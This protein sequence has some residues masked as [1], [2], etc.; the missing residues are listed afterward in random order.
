MSLARWVPSLKR[1]T[2]YTVLAATL[3]VGTGMAWQKIASAMDAK[4]YPPPGEFVNMGNYNIHFLKKGI[5][6]PVVV[7]DAG[8][9]CN[10]LDWKFVQEALA[11]QAQVVS[12]DRPGY[13]WSD[14]S[15]HPRTS[16]EIATELHEMLRRAH[17]A[18][19]YV[20]VGHSFGGMN[21]RQFALQYPEE[22]AGLVF[23]DSCHE[24]QSE[25]IPEE[26]AS[27]TEA[28]TSL[29]N[30]EQSLWW[31]TLGVSR[32]FYN[33]SPVKKDLNVFPPAVKE[34]YLTTLKTSK[35]AKVVQDETVLFDQSSL[36][37]KQAD[38]HLKNIPIVVLTAGSPPA[39]DAEDNDKLW[40]EFHKAIAA[41]ST[42]S[43]HLYAEGSGHFI[44]WEKPQI[45]I[46]AI[47]LLIPKS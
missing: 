12:Y 14:L 26:P 38:R 23:V 43:T 16:A 5:K 37:L 29:G 41:K 18:A 27:G 17:I 46:R 19:P 9:G 47:Q 15:P 40:T 8:L 25:K 2:L 20:L 10:H 13:G 39:D 7:L 34:A 35:F 6:G 42:N 44:P 3:L 31:T 45:V 4:A 32:F 11:S 24:E 1:A 28:W 30:P 33:F 21:I 36:Q 22:V